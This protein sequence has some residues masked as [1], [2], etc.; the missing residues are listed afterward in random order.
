M[1]V[2]GLGFRLYSRLVREFLQEKYPIGPVDLTCLKPVDL[3]EFV[4]SRAKRDKPNI[5]GI[6]KSLRSLALFMQ[7]QGLCDTQL[8]SAIPTAPRWTP[9]PLPKHLTAE[10]LAKLLHSFERSTAAGKRDYAMS[11]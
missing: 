1:A 11:L 9:S 6:T 8:V 7:M 2:F 4:A 5:E 3:I 10:Q